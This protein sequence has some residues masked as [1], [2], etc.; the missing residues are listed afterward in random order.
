MGEGGFDMK[1]L[2]K[3][4]DDLLNAMQQ[5]KPIIDGAE[6]MINKVAGGPLGNLL[7]FKNQN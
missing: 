2:K 1:Q 4:Q 6:G 7:G 3:Q 5:M